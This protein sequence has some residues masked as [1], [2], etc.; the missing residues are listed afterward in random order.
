MPGQQKPGNFKAIVLHENYFMYKEFI[1]L[2]NWQCALV[3]QA[4]YFG[5]VILVTILQLTMN[6]LRRH[7]LQ[8]KTAHTHDGNFLYRQA[9]QILAAIID[10]F[11]NCD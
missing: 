11:I 3:V 7:D 10:S 1:Y 2:S 8:S 4:N 5:A 9:G 6:F